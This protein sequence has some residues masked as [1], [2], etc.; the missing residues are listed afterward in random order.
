MS[1]Y[2]PIHQAGVCTGNMVLGDRTRGGG[3]GGLASLSQIEFQRL[4]YH[5]DMGEFF[6]ITKFVSL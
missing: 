4:T 1:I 3:D 6:A 5:H 2:W